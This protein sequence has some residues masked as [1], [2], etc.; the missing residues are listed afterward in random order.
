MA[1]KKY[2]VVLGQVIISIF[3]C[4]DV[5]HVQRNVLAKFKHRLVIYVWSDGLGGAT[6]L[7]ES[8]K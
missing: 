1:T 5:E 3:R 4:V 2:V 7:I 6:R 8:S